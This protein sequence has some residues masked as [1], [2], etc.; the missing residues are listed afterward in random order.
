MPNNPIALLAVSTNIDK[1]ASDDV[2]VDHNRENSEYK[3]II[4]L[5]KK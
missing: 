1:I 4:M 3:F 2:L 5:M